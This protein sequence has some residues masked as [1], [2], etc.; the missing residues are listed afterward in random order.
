MKKHIYILLFILGI[1]MNS[2]QNLEIPPSNVLT[3]ESVF[4][5]RSGVEAYVAK[6]YRDLPLE[7]FLCSSNKAKGWNNIDG[8]SGFGTWAGLT[9]E[10]IGHSVKSQ[11]HLDW[12]TE[13]YKMLREINQFIE[14][15]PEFAQSHPQEDI[16]QWLGEAYFMRAFAY[17][18]MAI[19][20]GG[21]IIVNDVLTYPNANGDI[22]E[23]MIARSSEEATWDQIASDYDMAIELLGEN[24]LRSRAN[25]YVAAAYKSRSMLFAA[26]IAKYNTT[27][28]FDTRDQT[29][30]CG[31]P[32]T[33]AADFYLE[34]YNAAKM[35]EA[36]YQLY[37]GDW[38]AGDPEAIFKN[39]QNI[40][41][42]PDNGESILIREYQYPTYVHSFD[43]LN[44][45]LQFRIG[46]VASTTCPTAEYVALFDGLDID[47]NG[48]LNFLDA[49]GN[50]IMYDYAF[51]PFENIEPR[52][53]A[54][55]L[56]PG[57]TFWFNQPLEVWRG[58]Y[59][60]EIAGGVSKF[61]PRTSLSKYSTVP[62]IISS[63]NTTGINSYTL[64]TGEVTT[65]SG[66]SGSFNSEGYGSKTGFELRK[67]LNI[68]IAEGMNFRYLSEQDWIDMRY[69]EVML[70]RAE[71]AFEL[72]SLGQNG[73]D[74][75]N[76]AFTMIN[77]IR[78]R[79]GAVL[80]NNQGELSLEAIRKERL[81]E[82]GFEN[83]YYWDLVRWRTYDKEQSSARRY[84]NAFAFRVSKNGKWIYDL[85]YSENT[86]YNFTFKP[87]WYYMPI[88]EDEIGKN[89]NLV[90]NPI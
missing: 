81:K 37:M 46:G 61:L 13:G 12:W 58:I 53:R 51:Q 86:G 41:Q 36:K 73:A 21:V 54:T 42:Y 70:I 84:S 66:R 43:A 77:E 25:K 76:D 30:L 89:T 8:S 9:G 45:P 52:G 82:L 83:K 24:S 32:D 80:L 4:S 62:D 15:L 78:N 28:H 79:A 16:N 11:T 1:S 17:H 67:N 87:S 40:H 49:N 6:M 47:E 64:E 75:L 26:S 60:G 50:Y 63:A 34:A 27:S 55:V 48:D 65:N 29:R 7:D 31:I 2:C 56:L 57:D 68:N 71:A 23:Y 5:T 33:R 38:A 22:S 72:N 3:N 69:A 18:T 85:K 88:P 59:T 35:C 39:F 90:Q 14:T 10:A 74:Y 20:Y 44:S 19:R